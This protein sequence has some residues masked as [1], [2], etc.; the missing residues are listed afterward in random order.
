[1]LS[2]KLVK[3]CGYIFHSQTV[4]PEICQ[5]I[6]GLK[7]ILLFYFSSTRRINMLSFTF[8][9]SFSIVMTS[10]VLSRTEFSS[11]LKTVQ[12]FIDSLDSLEC[13]HGPLKGWVT[14]GSTSAS[15]PRE[16]KFAFIQHCPTGNTNHLEVF[17]SSSPP[18][19]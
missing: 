9:Y 19:Q 13:W 5:N 12:Y 1:M 16:V 15:L 10:S 2:K 14:W 7:Y 4:D 18:L 11:R 3:V 6:L 17:P 8:I